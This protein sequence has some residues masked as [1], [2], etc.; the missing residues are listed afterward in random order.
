[1]LNCA[2]IMGR[3]TS[4]PEVRNTPSGVSV[5]RFTVA[6]DRAYVK[7]GEERK[8]DFIDVLAWRNTAEFV[9]KYFGKGSM[10]AVQGSI[11]TGTYEKDGIK[12]RTFEIVADNVSFCGGKENK[13]DSGSQVT[14]NNF[15]PTEIDDDDELD[16]PF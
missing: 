6:V 12:R 13:A 10:I 2:V 8:A 3:L 5:C 15:E 9:G 1:M 11:Q 7:Q 14:P 16:L 4:D